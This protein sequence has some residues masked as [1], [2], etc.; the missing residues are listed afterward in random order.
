MKK[1]LGKIAALSTLLTLFGCD[2][3]GI[4]AKKELKSFKDRMTAITDFTL[5]SDKTAKPVS[6]D[7]H[8]G[9]E[10]SF[11][12]NFEVVVKGGETVS[13]TFSAEKRDISEGF[14][15]RIERLVLSDGTEYETD[16]NWWGG[17]FMGGREIQKISLKTAE[18]EDV[19]ECSVINPEDDK[20][21]RLSCTKGD[22]A[23]EITESDIFD[24]VKDIRNM[25]YVLVSAGKE[26]WF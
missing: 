24:A 10:N 4:D 16:V 11:S 25:A 21:R 5:L 8:E 6:A 12:V 1:G 22:M 2:D 3:N 7:Y 20:N 14:R 15:K 19:L 13:G 9:G 18:S 23:Q 26:N 17:A